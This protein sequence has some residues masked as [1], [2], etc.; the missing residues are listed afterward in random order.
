MDDLNKKINEYKALEAQAQARAI[1]QQKVNKISAVVNTLFIF[2]AIIVFAL[3]MAGCAKGGATTRVIPQKNDIIVEII[4]KDEAKRA[5]G[6][7]E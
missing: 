5:L 6:L 2:L 3:S 7:G 1:K 4:A